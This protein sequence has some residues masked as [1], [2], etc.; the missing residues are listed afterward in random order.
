M[1]RLASFL[2]S[3]YGLIF[4]VLL[5][6]GIAVAASVLAERLALEA[7]IAGERAQAQKSA[8]RIVAEVQRQNAFHQLIALAIANGIAA[9]PEIDQARFGRLVQPFLDTDPD[10]INVGVAEGYTIKHVYPVHQNRSA[11]GFDYRDDPQQLAS[12]Q[13]AKEKE[14]AVFAGEV[15]LVQGGIGY[16]YRAPVF[17]TDHLKGR[18]SYWGI[19]SVVV[20]GSHFHEETLVPANSDY[21]V[22]VRKVGNSPDESGMIWGDAVAFEGDPVLQQIDFGPQIWELAIRPEA[23]WP[24]RA[25]QQSTIRG[26]VAILGALAVLLLLWGRG[27]AR[28][29]RKVWRQLNEAIECI[30]E[31][32]ALY[33]PD[34][35]LV[36]CNSRYK[37]FYEKSA[38]MMVPGEKFE[39]IIRAGVSKGQ[40]LDAVGR[41]EQWIQE[42]LAEHRN[43]TGAFEQR[44]G[45]DRWLKVSE[46]KLS[47]G[48][49]AG[50]RV[51]VTELKAAMEAAESANRA[52]TEFMNTMSHEIRT[53][54]SAVIGFAAILKHV[55]RL[56][57]FKTLHDIADKPESDP[58][59]LRGGL[60]NLRREIADF[61]GRID[62]N[63]SHL[64]SIINDILYWTGSKNRLQSETAIKLDVT[65][66]VESVVLQLSSIAEEKSLQLSAL[67][68]DAI[69]VEADATR[70]RQVLLNLVGNA[71]KFTSDG[72][73]RL[74]CEEEGDSV[75]ILIEDTGC[76]I[77]PE[78]FE[79][80]FE[81]FA[82]LDSSLTRA[83][84]GS[85]LGLAIS[86]DI[87]R[88]HGGEIELQ[89]EIGKGSVFIVRLPRIRADK[90]VA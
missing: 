85:G 33:G 42:R 30:Q 51:D 29:K 71:L 77:P 6:A 67:P 14:A 35:R 17:V 45:E 43:P 13:E 52:K 68:G 87:V 60:D 21:V 58:E 23:G 31:G 49:T 76:G 18:K 78:Q 84:G 80:V 2:D 12:V 47:D 16:I 1:T 46:N 37:S 73:V 39:N 15:Q 57:T 22:G 66:L 72:H 38:H 62:C 65:D 69:W 27:I 34:D 9:E 44:V 56:P 40:Y 4:S 89:S 26:I 59:A 61:A 48:S 10:I 63:G 74:R 8:S 20:S 64:L 11:L 28:A 32:F 53:P 50:F 70:L 55:D 24:A 7:E 86:R 90:D 25:S 83:Q 79:R 5:L 3:R 54:L 75:K 82:Q 88:R 36:L 41:E 19:V 81:A